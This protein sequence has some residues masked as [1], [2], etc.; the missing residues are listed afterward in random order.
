MYQYADGEKEWRMSLP[1]V[2]LI[3]NLH[4]LVNQTPVTSCVHVFYLALLYLFVNIHFKVDQ[5]VLTH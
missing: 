4:H 5:V 1:A 3:K 2:L